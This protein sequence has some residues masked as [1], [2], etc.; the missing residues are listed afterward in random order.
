[1]ILPMSGFFL[2]IAI[3]GGFTILLSK[4]K[5]HPAKQMPIGFSMLFAGIGYCSLAL[6]LYPLA[7]YLGTVW[8]FALLFF[9][10]FAGGLGGAIFGYRAGLKRAGI[11]AGVAEG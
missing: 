4:S 11:S 9:A 7:F 2:A 1:M 6:A 3:L 10:P 8:G 5:A